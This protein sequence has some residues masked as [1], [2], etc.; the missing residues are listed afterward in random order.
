MITR[1]QSHFIRAA[2]RA[3]LLP[4]IT[5][6]VLGLSSAV[7]EARMQRETLVL[8]TASGEVPIDIEV[9]ETEQDKSVGLMF[10][11]GRAHV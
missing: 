10:Q 8:R 4:L 11:I 1:I 3:A 9:T 2:L 6:I 5:L 7:G